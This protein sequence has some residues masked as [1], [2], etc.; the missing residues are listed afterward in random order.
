MSCML[1]GH[2]SI[3]AKISF[4]NGGH[5]MYMYMYMA[6]QRLWWIDILLSRGQELGQHSTYKVMKVCPHLPTKALLF[7]CI[8]KR[9]TT[10]RRPESIIRYIHTTS[11]ILMFVCLHILFCTFIIERVGTLTRWYV[12]Y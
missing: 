9:A 2:P 10:P 5:Y 8:R 6:H 4:H 3:M 7:L 11:L 12:Q 1:L